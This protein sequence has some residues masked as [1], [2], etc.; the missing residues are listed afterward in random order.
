M[1]GAGMLFAVG[2]VERGGFRMSKTATQT[3]TEP[4][5]CREYIIQAEHYDTIVSRARQAQHTNNW[6]WEQ[7]LEYMVV[8]MIDNRKELTRMLSDAYACRPVDNRIIAGE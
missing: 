4:R 6:T 2:V 1:D 8:S 7:T 5:S 3:P